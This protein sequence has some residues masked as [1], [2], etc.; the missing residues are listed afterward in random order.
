MD[1]ENYL[2]YNNIKQII[3]TQLTKI[4][5]GLKS[6]E[7]PFYLLQKAKKS[8]DGINI[9]NQKEI[10]KLLSSFNANQLAVFLDTLK[11]NIAHNKDCNSLLRDTRDIHKGRFPRKVSSLTIH[12]SGCINTYT[13]FMRA[14]E[15][16]T[17]YTTKIKI[18]GKLKR[19]FVKTPIGSIGINKD[20]GFFRL[21]IDPETMNVYSFKSDKSGKIDEKT[22]TKAYS[23]E[24]LRKDC[25]VYNPDSYAQMVQKNYNSFR[26]S[27]LD[28]IDAVYGIERVVN[29]FLRMGG[30]INPNKYSNLEFREEMIEHLE[31]KLGTNKLLEW[32]AKIG[33]PKK[34]A[35]VQQEILRVLSRKFGEDYER[36]YNFE[37]KIAKKTTK[38]KR[39]LTKTR[40][41]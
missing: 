38:T 35:E 41:L 29:T 13:G 1:N 26:R 25:E 32:T 27:L 36:F 11:Y 24:E 37:K 14:L 23:K 22:I 6:Y 2:L 19:V 20:S 40:R 16:G 4:K 7:F 34:A 18:D 33:D 28:R 31:E 8:L 30:K 17:L 39:K 5:Y 15:A 9:N 3:E 10:I 21:F 12:S